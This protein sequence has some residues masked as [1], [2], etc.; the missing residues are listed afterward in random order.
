VSLPVIL[1]VAILIYGI[2][3]S[4]YVTCTDQQA[5]TLDAIW[6]KSKNAYRLPNTLGAL[7]ELHK[8][9][10]DVAE[11]GK[12][13]AKQRDNLLSL[14]TAKTPDVTYPGIFGI[15]RN[16]RPYQKQT[17]IFFRIYPMQLFLMNSGPGKLLQR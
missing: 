10:F 1:L 2:L 4:L 13:K 9:G 8:L 6:M 16:L 11:Y 3:N 5:R 17:S 15:A 7:R 12:K 14:K